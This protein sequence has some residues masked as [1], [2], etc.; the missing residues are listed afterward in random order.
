MSNFARNTAKLM[1][2][3]FGAQLVAFITIPIITRYYSPDM[4]GVFSVYYS[5]VTVL[6]A[7]STLR[8]SNA[9]MLPKSEAVA[10]DLVTLSLGSVI[11]STMLIS[12][13]CVVVYIV[14]LERP[15]YIDAWFLFLVAV[16]VL[17]VGTVQS[18]NFW[19]LREK[20]FYRMGWSRFLE[21]IL[22]RS[23][24]LCL[25]VFSHASFYG[26]LVGRLVGLFCGINALL[27]GGRFSRL[28]SQICSKKWQHLK[29]SAYKYRNFPLY[30]TWAHLLIPVNRAL[31]VWVLMGFYSPAETGF[32]AL[33]QRVLNVPAQLTVDALSRTFLQKCV[34]DNN[35]ARDLAPNTL[36]LLGAVLYLVLPAVI[37]LLAYAAPLFRFI[38]GAEWEIAG[39]YVEIMSPALAIFFLYRICSIF[40]DVLEQQKQRLLFDAISLIFHSAALIVPSKLG[41]PVLDTL[42][43]LSVVS[44][45]VYLAGVIFLLA[46]IR[47]SFSQFLLIIIGKFAVFLPLIAGVCMVPEL[48]FSNEIFIG[49][50]VLAFLQFVVIFLADKDVRS[51][52]VKIIRL[53]SPV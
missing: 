15:D 21:S 6:G 50:T 45:M 24:V 46:K 13:I 26:L 43:L 36:K 17:L 10:I 11:F 8:F 29:D 3:S 7:V 12:A 33:G 18:I 23:F 35:E 22:D 48:S 4:F 52:T 30:S 38:F 27:S 49:L 32:F 51:L 14:W 37:I 19:S 39:R 41:W 53:K 16:G 44:C 5:L 34:E 31:P 9:S 40:F 25:L 28:K 42:R 20:L 2:G 1:A 47:V